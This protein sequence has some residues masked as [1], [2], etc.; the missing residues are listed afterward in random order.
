MKRL[1]IL[2]TAGF[3]AVCLTAC[4]ENKKEEATQAPTESTQVAAPTENQAQ[5]AAEA[6]AEAP[7][8]TEEQH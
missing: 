7:A 5:P 4:G 2:A 1:A 6:P 8:A 3:L